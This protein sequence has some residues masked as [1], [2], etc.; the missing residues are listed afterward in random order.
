M[1]E[2]FAQ[3]RATIMT[4]PSL[5]GGPI[6]LAYLEDEGVRAVAGAVSAVRV[7]KD[8]EFLDEVRQRG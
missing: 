8:S 5:G 7:L 2:D 3:Y 4:W 1:A 6:S